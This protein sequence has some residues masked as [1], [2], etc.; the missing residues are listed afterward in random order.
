MDRIEV[1]TMEIGI[2][3]SNGIDRYIPT[4]GILVSIIVRDESMAAVIVVFL[5]QANVQVPLTCSLQLDLK[6]RKYTL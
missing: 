4:V 6:R 1:R 5:D 3:K 2:E